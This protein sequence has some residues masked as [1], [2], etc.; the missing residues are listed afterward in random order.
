MEQHKW[1]YALLNRRPN[2]EASLDDCLTALKEV[3]H[4]ARACYE[5]ESS[6]ANDEFL[7]M[8]LVDGCLIHL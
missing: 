7:Q 2:L 5:E 4:R 8:I 3:E 6:F 1:R